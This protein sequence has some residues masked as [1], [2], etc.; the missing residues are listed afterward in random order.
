LP[1]A[2]SYGGKGKAAGFHPLA[3]GFAVWA[4]IQASPRQYFLVMDG[5][6]IAVAVGST[7]TA[8]KQ[9]IRVACSV[10]MLASKNNLISLKMRKVS[11]A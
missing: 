4:E 10:T 3:G 9:L 1:Q 11:A 2:A 6:L 5:S 7:F 8:G